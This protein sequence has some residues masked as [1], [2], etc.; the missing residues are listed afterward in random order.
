MADELIITEYGTVLDD[1]VCRLLL[2]LMNANI[3]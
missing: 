1:T 3:S 2:F